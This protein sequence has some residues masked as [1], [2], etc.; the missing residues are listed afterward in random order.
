MVGR[1]RLMMLNMD[2]PEHTRQRGFAGQGFTPR[3]IGRLVEHV[4][5]ICG[6]LIDD[7]AQRG[8]A[9]FA[10]DIAAPLPMQVICELV[11]AP[12]EDR[13]RLLELSD[14]VFGIDDPELGGSPAD[15]AQA[16]A[17]MLGYAGALAERRRQQ[18]RDDIVAMIR[19]CSARPRRPGCLRRPAQASGAGYPDCRAGR[20]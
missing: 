7:V 13:G 20:Q 15:G 10:A 5:Q 11:G 17:E 8:Q 9:D 6:S 18:P 1:L 12:P 4:T 16:T 19:K 14:R 2:P 3:M